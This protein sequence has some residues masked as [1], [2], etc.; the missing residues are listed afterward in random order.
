MRFYEERQEKIDELLHILQQ[1][2][3]ENTEELKAEL[4]K[5]YD[6]I[7]QLKAQL[8]NDSLKARES[9]EWRDKYESVVNTPEIKADTEAAFNRGAEHQRKKFGAWMMNTGQQILNEEPNE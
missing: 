5:A 3:D 2:A 6:E 1:S 4:S 7:N 8:N 9:E